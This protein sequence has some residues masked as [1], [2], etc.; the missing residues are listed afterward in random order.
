MMTNKQLA[1]EV[2]Q[3]IVG[4]LITIIL[5]FLFLLFVLLKIVVAIVLYSF[6]KTYDR[7]LSKN[8]NKRH[9]L[10]F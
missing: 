2:A 3:I 10:Y 1:L 4:T 8:K 9:S 6:N 5:L 7:P